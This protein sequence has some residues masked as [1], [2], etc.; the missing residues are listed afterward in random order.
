LFDQ[1]F[2]EAREAAQVIVDRNERKQAEESENVSQQSAALTAVA[3]AFLVLQPLLYLYDASPW[4]VKAGGSV[5]A[6]LAAL[7]LILGFW[8]PSIRWQEQLRRWRWWAVA[9]LAVA[10]LFPVAERLWHADSGGPADGSA[11]AP[12]VWKWVWD[13]YDGGGKVDASTPAPAV[14]QAP[15]T[16]GRDLSPPSSVPARTTVPSRERPPASSLPKEPSS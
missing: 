14:K 2:E 16:S 1:V 4:Y 7:I 12:A 8:K 3:T 11:R 9:V 13:W 5:L 6:S 15:S 10:V